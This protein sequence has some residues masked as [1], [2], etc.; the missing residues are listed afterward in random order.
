MLPLPSPLPVVGAGVTEY[1]SV[2]T[3]D[4]AANLGAMSKSTHADAVRSN[5]EQSEQSVLQTRQRDAVR[6]PKTYGGTVS[7]SMASNPKISMNV[8]RRQTQHR[9]YIPMSSCGGTSVCV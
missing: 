4:M 5:R 6:S 3:H 7:H 9:R 8:H 2:D 1:P